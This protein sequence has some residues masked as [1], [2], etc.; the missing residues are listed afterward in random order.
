MDQNDESRVT[1]GMVRRQG[2]S[3]PPER[4]AAV[5]AAAAVVRKA[6]AKLEDRLDFSADIYGFIAHQR[7]WGQDHD[8]I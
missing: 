5:A 4:E 3:L 8:D 7:R 2:V 1:L 6:A